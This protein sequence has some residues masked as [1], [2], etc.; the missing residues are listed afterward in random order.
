[1]KV[2]VT[3]MGPTLDSSV[4]PSFG[5]SP[6]ILIVEGENL[7]EAIQNP[8]TTY[9]HGAGV[10]TAQLVASKGVSA[11]IT[12]NVGPNAYSVLSQ[13]GIQIYAAIPGTVRDNVRALSEG[14]LQP[15]VPA[16]RRG[17]GWRR[18]W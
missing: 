4:F 17:W 12:G 1:M 16:G 13:L 14:R 5:R 11:V 15:I 10:A 2:A 3:A 7:L 9:A 18:P 6:Y 8:A